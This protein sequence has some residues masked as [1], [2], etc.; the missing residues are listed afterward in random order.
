M[1]DSSRFLTLTHSPFT[2]SAVFIQANTAGTDVVAGCASN[3]G[4]FGVITPTLDQAN[5]FYATDI[6]AGPVPGGPQAVCDQEDPDKC[7]CIG[8]EV[9][10]FKVSLD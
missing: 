10:R 9:M 8:D 1:F 5:G 6:G 4:Y 2:P 3:A 7:G